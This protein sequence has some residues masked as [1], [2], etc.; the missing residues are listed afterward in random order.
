ML[1]KSLH[2]SWA[3][4]ML[5]VGVVFGTVLGIVFR[6]SYFSSWWFLVVAGGMILF[7]LVKPKFCFM[8]VALIAG[9]ILAFFRIAGELSG[10][11]TARELFGE[12]VLVTGEVNGDAETDEKGTKVK[13]VNIKYGDK[14]ASGSLY[15]S[16]R[17]NEEIR[18]SDTLV[19]YGAIDEGFSTYVGY[20]Y[21]P[22]VLKILRP[23]PGDIILTVRD[24]FSER[25]KEEIPDEEAKLGMSYLLGMKAGLSDELSENLRMVGLTHIVVASGAHLS[26]LVEIAKKLFG[27][28]SRFAGLT[29]SIVF[30]V[31]FMMLVGWTPSIMRAGVMTIL[32]LSCWYVGRKMAPL[33]MILLVAAGTLMVNPNFIINMGW[34]LSFASFSGI[35]LVGPWMTKWF[36]GDKKPGFIASMIITT[37]AATVMTLPIVLYFYGQVSLILLA[38]NL[39]ILP[40]LPYAMGLVFT[41]GVLAG[42]PFVGEVAGFITTK[43]LDYHIAVVNFFGELKQFLVQISEGNAWVFL[44]YVIVIGGM[45]AVFI[46]GKML[47]KKT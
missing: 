3:V 5:A 9:M 37:L 47:A 44:I 18:R 32:S 12:K 45:L 36:Y 27:K 21:Q 35:M 14:S 46:K 28:I 19:L 6:I 43:L 13:L 33:R 29:F 7:V 1:M 24:W 10:E 11:M 40:T 22:R 25:V 4:V 2:Q 17:K 8:V 15:V 20:M 42:V 30:I 39:L 31:L 34:L 26:I 38:A 41:T 16:L 23:E